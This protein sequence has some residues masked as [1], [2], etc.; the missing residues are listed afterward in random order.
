M[1]SQ[2]SLGSKL[3]EIGIIWMTKEKEKKFSVEAI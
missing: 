3:G 1:H 2:I